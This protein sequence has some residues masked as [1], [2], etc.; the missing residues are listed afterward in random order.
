MKND[1]L[2]FYVVMRCL[3]IESQIILLKHTYFM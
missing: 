3:G 1:Q 2:G